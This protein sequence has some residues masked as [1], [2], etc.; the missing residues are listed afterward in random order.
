MSMRKY[1]INTIKRYIP[2]FAVSA[3]VLFSLFLSVSMALTSYYYKPEGLSYYVNTPYSGL[4]IYFI[5]LV[6]LSIITPIFA[7]SYRY[8]LKSVDLFYQ[9]GKG[10][11]SIRFANNAV[12][13]IGTLIVYTVMIMFSFIILLLKQIPLGGQTIVDQYGSEYTYIIFNFGFY[14]LA[15][16]L[17]VIFCTL[18]YFISYFLVTRSNYVWNSLVTLFFGEVLLIVGVMTPIWYSLVIVNR[19]TYFNLYNANV[20][21]G[22]R[23]MSIVCPVAWIAHIFEPLIIG[24][25]IEFIIAPTTVA[26]LVLAIVFLVLFIALSIVCML[27]FFKEKESSGELA[28]KAMG[29]DKLQTIIF[30]TGFGVAALWLGMAGSLLS[31]YSIF[32]Y[33]GILSSFAT[34]GALYYVFS[35]LQRKNF[36]FNKKQW[37]LYL[38]IMGIYVIST[39]INI[40]LSFIQPN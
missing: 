18:N 12:L 14:I 38:S 9:T 15:Y 26:S 32:N 13:W 3:A 6:L 1:V 10:D 36:K 24:S 28:G 23:C 7:N 39:I 35:S 33:F 8:S 37:A 22:T 25:E 34:F 30:H 29:R 40:V 27:F 20:L 17:L 4:L 5:P 31:S 19:F 11:K 2:F 16:L 21:F